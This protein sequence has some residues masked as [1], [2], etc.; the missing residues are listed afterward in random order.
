MKRYVVGF[1]FDEYLNFVM[2]L[3]RNK[4]P[5]LGY[6]NGIGGKIEEKDALFDLPDRDYAMLREMEEETGLSKD[7]IKKYTYLMTINYPH[8]IE[9]NIYSIIL[10]TGAEYLPLI[11]S[12]EGELLWVHAN[13]NELL[14]VYSNQFAG[15]GNIAYAI[16]YAKF[17]EQ[18]I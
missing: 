17:I 13:D 3:K 6:M 1:I 2:M 15:E 16:R 7:K 9:L 18:G 5:Y 12:D 4:N 8:G 10:Q 11:N 14:N